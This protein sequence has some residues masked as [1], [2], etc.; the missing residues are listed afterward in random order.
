MS[1]NS[2]NNIANL[3]P[4]IPESYLNRGTKFAFYSYLYTK[5]I[6]INYIETNSLENAGLSLK[7]ITNLNIFI[8]KEQKLIGSQLRTL[9]IHIFLHI[10][11]EHFLYKKKDNYLWNIATDLAI[12]SN[13]KND[14]LGLDSLPKDFNF[15]DNKTAEYYY[16]ELQNKNI[17]K[18]LKTIDAHRYWRKIEDEENKQFKQITKEKSI[19][20]KAYLKKIL[21][22]TYNKVKTNNYY[23]P[24]YI[25]EYFI[26]EYF[27]D[28]NYNINHEIKNQ[29]VDWKIILK[30]QIQC[31]I[32]NYYKKSYSR[33]SRRFVKNDFLLKGNITKRIAKVCLAIDTSR[34]ISS[35]Q[36]KI[37]W[38]ELYTIYKQYPIELR[39]I[40]WDHDQ[41]KQDIL[42]YK[43]NS[44]Y[45][46]YE[47]KF[48][49]YGNTKLRDFF[50]YI[51]KT[52]K[53]QIFKTQ[54]YKKI[55][56]PDLLIF[57]VDGNNVYF[58]N[59]ENCTNYKVLWCVVGNESKSLQEIPFGLKIKINQ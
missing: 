21:T 45:K 8:N 33:P 54:L 30:N 6:E 29:P 16:K 27:N 44:L 18:N 55:S 10:I 26:E 48:N 35:K 11:Y 32:K 13:L 31:S 17:D 58:P 56:R 5:Y 59:K 15:A 24:N 1:N 47:P 23:V 37:L 20:I 41:V 42:Y 19:I 50:E 51:R 25:E 4:Y 34:D 49:G 46:N 38:R 39:I 12:N 3:F 43:K 2:N 40:E 52:S 28:I 57:F 36:F 53:V 9:L 22:D 7:N 14:G